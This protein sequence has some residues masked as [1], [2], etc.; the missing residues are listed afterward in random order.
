[1][2][3]ILEKSSEFCS[4][5]NGKTYVAVRVTTRASLNAVTGVKN[6]QLLV[7][8]TSAPEN[9]KANLAVI[10]ILSEVLDVPK[11]KIEIISGAKCRTKV[12]LIDAAKI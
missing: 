9:N 7:S 8:V 4:F 11:S 3:P 5:K 1:M 12:C 2:H 10:K 6:G